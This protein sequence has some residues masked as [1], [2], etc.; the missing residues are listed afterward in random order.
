M[1]EE[2]REAAAGDC[3]GGVREVVAWEVDEA[4]YAVADSGSCFDWDRGLLPVAEG[5]EFVR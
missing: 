5:V 1:A 3:S 2:A 4:A